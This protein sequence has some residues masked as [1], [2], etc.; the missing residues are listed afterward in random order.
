MIDTYDH[1][2]DQKS[3]ISI[4][5]QFR[6]TLGEAFYLT[7]SD[8]NCLEGYTEEAYKKISDE[9]DEIDPD[10]G[11]FWRAN[12]ALCKIDA[13]GR[14]FIPPEYRDEIGLGENVTI[15][16]NGSMLQFWSTDEWKNVNK[17]NRKPEKI[18]ETKKRLRELR[19]QKR[20]NR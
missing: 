20:N 13:Q 5:A 8:K 3:R 19:Q 1:L 14:A 18:A 12:T 2:L 7:F 4:P 17:E 9:L 16:G 6:R 15:V 11:L 10:E